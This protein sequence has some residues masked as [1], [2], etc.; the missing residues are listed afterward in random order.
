MSSRV[1]GY[2]RDELPRGVNFVA[3]H[4]EGGE[5]TIVIPRDADPATITR[6]K[7][8]LRERRRRQPPSPAS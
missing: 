6:V 1:Y 3:V 4:R 7:A 5:P 8:Y 2:R